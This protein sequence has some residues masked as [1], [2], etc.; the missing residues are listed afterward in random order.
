MKS[1]Q[2]KRERCCGITLCVIYLEAA[3][4]AMT[5]QVRFRDDCLLLEMEHCNSCL[6]T[7]AGL[8]NDAIGRY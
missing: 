3:A 1:E 2:I 6:E 8:E 4:G 5:S 7:F